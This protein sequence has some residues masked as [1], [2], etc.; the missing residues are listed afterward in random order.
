MCVVNVCTCVRTCVR[1][2]VCVCVR[3]RVH[4]VIRGPVERKSLI[5]DITLFVQVWMQDVSGVKTLYICHSFVLAI[6]VHVDFI[7]RKHMSWIL[8]FGNMLMS[9]VQCDGAHY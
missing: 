5:V 7:F 8:F 2:R 4:L 6:T 3:V 9:G 1:V